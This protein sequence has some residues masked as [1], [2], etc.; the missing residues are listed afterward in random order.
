MKTFRN[1]LVFFVVFLILIC[2]QGFG[3]TIDSLNQKKLNEYEVRI[4]DL[5]K[6]VFDSKV[7][8]FKVYDSTIKFLNESQDNN[9]KNL[10][11][12]YSIIATIIGI[13]VFLI[14][15]GAYAMFKTYKYLKKYSEEQVTSYIEKKLSPFGI[16][17]QNYHKQ[18]RRILDD[19]LFYYQLFQLLS[20]E[21]QRRNALEYFKQSSEQT[22]PILF[23]FLEKISNTETSIPILVDTLFVLIIN[24]SPP[25]LKNKAK[26]K[27]KELRTIESKDEKDYVENAITKLKDAFAIIIN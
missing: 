14:G 13:I 11:I 3:Q 26:T 19:Q 18:F 27:L 16:D 23:A 22:D 15:G 5:E 24:N 21:E 2:N 8:T 12:I 9:L 10:R 1:N 7:E 6:L 4:K 25:A 20:N 17:S